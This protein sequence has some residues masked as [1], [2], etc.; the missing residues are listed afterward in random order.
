MAAIIANRAINCII[1]VYAMVLA[2]FSYSLGQTSLLRSEIAI[3]VANFLNCNEG[4]L[5]M[6]RYYVVMRF[7]GQGISP[8]HKRYST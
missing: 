6:C 5:R 2:L 7:Q 8:P 4:L 1:Y 3:W